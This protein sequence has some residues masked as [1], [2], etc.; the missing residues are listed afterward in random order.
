MGKLI[1]L[2]LAGALGWW[3][4]GK[5]FRDSEPVHAYKAFASAW[6]N[7]RPDQAAGLTAGPSASRAIIEKSLYNLMG[8]VPVQH[9]HGVGF[10]I[11]SELPRGSSV[12]I[13]AV[14][15]VAYDPPGVTSALGGAAKADVRQTVE[16]TQ[17]TDGWKVISFEPVLLDDGLDW[18]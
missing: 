6:A 9:V 12:L 16:M 3:A 5:Y 11:E 8:G 2:V 7:A 15:T 18:K 10:E 1:V 13:T 17:T 4:Y 14:Q